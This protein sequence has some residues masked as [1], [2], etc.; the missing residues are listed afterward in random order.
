MEERGVGVVEGEREGARG[1]RGGGEPGEAGGG[2]GQGRALFA[3]TA[4]NALMGWWD[5]GARKRREQ[6]VRAA[7]HR[8][9]G[10]ECAASVMA[11][12]RTATGGSVPNRELCACV[13]WRTYVVEGRDLE[14]PL[15]RFV[16]GGPLHA[17]CLPHANFRA[18]GVPPGG[19][20]AHH[21]ASVTTAVWSGCLHK[22]CPCMRREEGGGGRRRRVSGGS[23]VGRC[24]VRF[25]SP[26]PVGDGKRGTSSTS[27]RGDRN[28]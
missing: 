16:S 2:R 6:S 8:D 5:V 23:N 9:C 13:Y 25:A 22:G 3:A 19:A 12:D 15:F 26:R 7:G 21:G 18:H 4:F 11:R 27:K 10:G 1:R 24:R 14:W 20:G 17:A 28:A